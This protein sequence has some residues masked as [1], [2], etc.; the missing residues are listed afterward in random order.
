MPRCAPAGCV[1]R[2]RLR[3]PK[4]EGCGEGR[5]RV[6]HPHLYNAGHM[7]NL[8]I[9]LFAFSAAAAAAQSSAAVPRAPEQLGTVSFSVSCSPAVQAS[10]NRGVALLHDFW[11]AESQPQF[12]RIAHEDPGCAMAHWGIAMSV[13]HQIW[14]RPDKNAMQTGW[15]EMQKAQSIGAKT[16]REQA[17]IAA[18]GDFY[19]PGDADFMTRVTAYSAAMGRLYA[20][21]PGDVDTPGRSTRCRCWLPKLRTTR[22]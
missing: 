4:R 3:G 14:D 17:Y 10:F 5:E 18:L 22:A 15:E 6:L 21:Y 19:R 16:Q 1:P 9:C 12:E 20:R 13:F 2:A 7:K 8:L 11:Y